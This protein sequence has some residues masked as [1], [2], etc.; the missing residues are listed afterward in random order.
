MWRSWLAT[1]SRASTTGQ[2]APRGHSALPNARGPAHRACA[3]PG[4]RTLR[5][6]P[7]GTDRPG[8]DRLSHR[9]LRH[10]HGGPVLHSDPG[11]AGAPQRIGVAE[12]GA[13]SNASRVYPRCARGSAGSQR[14]RQSACLARRGWWTTIRTPS[15]TAL[16]VTSSI[17]FC[18]LV[19]PNIFLTATEDDRVD[20][21]AQLVDEVVSFG[22]GAV[23][24]GWIRMPSGGPGGAGVRDAGGGRVGGVVAEVPR[25]GRGRAARRRRGGRCGRRGPVS[26]GSSSAP[27]DLRG[28]RRRGGPSPR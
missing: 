8:R 11:D 17:G 20:H 22:R 23:V 19:S 26:P 7:R 1:G 4:G 9:R 5:G 15:P 21:L 18:S 25:P 3:D 13:R 10:V 28:T 14:G 16:A 24:G 6:R 27:R 12:A 2:G